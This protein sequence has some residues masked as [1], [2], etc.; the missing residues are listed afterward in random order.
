[1]VAPTGVT[2]EER[3]RALP[4]QV[5]EVMNYSIPQGATGALA[6][7]QLWPRGLCGMEPGFLPW[8]SFHEQEELIIYF[9]PA[10]EAASV[11][12]DVWDIILILP[13]E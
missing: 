6:V 7:A 1:M 10:S 5:M 13:C 9:Q 8:S 11:L 3:L 2:V 4:A 12:M